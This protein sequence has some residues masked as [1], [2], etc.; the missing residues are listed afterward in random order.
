M[1]PDAPSPFPR[2]RAGAIAPL[3]LL[4][5]HVEP[6][7]AAAQVR[8][9]V[10]AGL[11][12]ASAL[13]RDSIVEP[14]SLRANPAL[15]LAVDVETQLTPRYRLGVGLGVARSDLT[16]RTPAGDA[17]VTSLTVWHPTLMLRHGATDWLTVEAA[18]GV[19]LY[20][21]AQRDGT[22]FRDGSPVDPVVGIGVEAIR[23]MGR[24][25]QLGVGAGYDLHRFTTSTLQIRGFSGETTV[26][27][28]R[29][30]VTVR[31][32]LSGS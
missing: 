22:I 23:P 1:R 6:G 9:G 7:S 18:L 24:R 17:L 28:V 13:V 31:H 32:A 30:H 12:A 4:F 3:V 2:L 26:H 27:R 29:V 14:I 15:M 25:M 19:L 20:D 11:V 21:P 16:S 5:L 8:A 10:R